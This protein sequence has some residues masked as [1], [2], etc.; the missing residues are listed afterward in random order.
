LAIN[1]P[2][3]AA[4][5]K[6]MSQLENAIT[7]YQ[8]S[9]NVQNLI[10]YYE[11]Q[12]AVRAVAYTQETQSLKASGIT[13]QTLKDAAEKLR[14][15]TGEPVSGMYLGYAQTLIPQLRQ[16]MSAGGK[17]P[18]QSAALAQALEAAQQYV[19]SATA[20]IEQE[21]DQFADQ[22]SGMTGQPAPPGQFSNAQTINQAPTPQPSDPKFSSGLGPETPFGSPPRDR[23]TPNDV[24]DPAHSVRG[25]RG[26]TPDVPT[27]MGPQL[28]NS[29]STIRHEKP[30]KRS[31]IKRGGLNPDTE[32]QGIYIQPLPAYAP[33]EAQLAGNKLGD[34]TGPANGNDMLPGSNPQKAVSADSVEAAQRAG[35]GAVVPSNMEQGVFKSGYW[36]GGNKGAV[37][38]GALVFMGYQTRNTKYIDENNPRFGTQI[39]AT[40]TPIYQS[41]AG[42]TYALGKEGFPSIASYQKAMGLAVTDRLNPQTVK[43]WNETLM[44]A[45]INTASNYPTTVQQAMAL[46]INAAN[47]MIKA[48]RASMAAS[49]RVD[50]TASAA[51]LGS[52]MKQVTGRLSNPAEDSEFHRAFNSANI[53]SQGKVD[54]QQFARDWVRGKYP[55]EAG[56]MAG[57]DYYGAMYDVLTAGPG[58]LGSEAADING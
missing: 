29:P 40:K 39:V 1:D 50:P 3:K 5:E 11:A 46:Q 13:A 54:A 42:L 21:D 34:T 52:A 2:S 43:A 23:R 58:S 45:S 6:A 47:Q 22:Y 17:S 12:N 4:Y 37:H 26:G 36:F 8:T 25:E 35:D 30:A 10:A 7:A 51:I 19:E 41:V 18:E 16:A 20:R 55:T 33:W 48:Q 44:I 9:P 28:F 31:R 24:A 57:Q 14:P 27:G 32:A 38:S 49:Y 15:S 53:S 56:T